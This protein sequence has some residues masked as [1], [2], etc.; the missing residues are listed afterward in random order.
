MVPIR[1]S[2]VQRKTSAE[3]VYNGI[4]GLNLRR[5][6]LFCSQ[7]PLH[8]AVRDEFGA[9][10]FINFGKANNNTNTNIN[11]NS[12]VSR[13]VIISLG[14]QLQIDAQS[15]ER[16]SFALYVLTLCLAAS[17]CNFVRFFHPVQ[18]NYQYILG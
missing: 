8:D 15:S 16:N 12:W 7:I 5:L 14:G 6:L 10:L 9:S 17:M 18:R 4:V 2:E 3:L 1:L 13:D 11:D